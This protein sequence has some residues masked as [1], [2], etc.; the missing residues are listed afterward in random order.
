MEEK[1][2]T[3]LSIY[4]PDDPT[5]DR[6]EA[7]F[8]GVQIH[9]TPT[10]EDMEPH[11]EKADII[12]HSRFNDDLLKR[13]SRLKWF[14]CS[15]AGFDHLLTP[16]FVKSPV[17]LTNA[18]GIH[19]IT[20]SEHAFAL[21][22]SLT[23]NI[24]R[25][26]GQDNVMDTW[27]RVVGEELYG[28]VA[29]VLGCGRIGR[30]IALKAHAFGMHVRACDMVPA[31]ASY[32]NAF[33]EISRIEDFFTGLDVLFVV[34]SVNQDTRG[35]VNRHLISLMRPGSYLINISRGVTVA[36]PDLIDALKNGPLAGAGLDVFETEPLPKDNELRRLP[37]V[38]L[39]AH[40]AG[41]SPKYKER[42]FDIFVENLRRWVEIR[43]GRDT[44]LINH[45][46]K[47]A[48]K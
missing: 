43:Q 21:L 32:L 27:E 6:I 35:L 19:P 1:E 15:W 9:H 3:I 48:E 24:Y 11:I 42:V 12:L 30:E 46:D 13:A 41:N 10:V 29:G 20:V 38:V 4:E 23:R 17:I 18:T 7:I 36:E 37:N 44:K 2:L 47:R 45:I 14:Q 31:V 40:L 5:K 28:K 33:Y 34:V 22:L 8:P 39:T 26:Y 16:D 25:C